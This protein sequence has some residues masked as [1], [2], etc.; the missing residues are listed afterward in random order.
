MKKLEWNLNELFESDDQFYQSIKEVK[1]SVQKFM[2]YKQEILDDAETLKKALIEY[3]KIK[4]KLNNILIYGS[5][6]YYKNINS[7]RA[8]NL[9]KDAECFNNEITTTLKFIDN[10]ILELGLEKIT[11]FIEENPKLKIYELS[12]HNLFRMKTHIQSD[13]INQKIKEINNHINDNINLYNQLIKDIKYGAIEINGKTIEICSSNFAKYISS[14]NREI[15]QKT[16]L[17]VNK[18]FQKESNQFSDILNH[19][20]HYRIEMAKIENY[21]TVLE[22]VLFTE[23]ID[24]K[25]LDSLIE[26]VN[27][28]LN[29]IQEYLKIKSDMLGIETP[30]LYDFGVPLDSDLK[31][32]YSLEDAVSIIKNALSPLGSEYMKAVEYLLNGHIDAIP[33]ENKHQSITFSWHTYSFMNFRGSYV[34]LKNMIHELGHIVN[35]YL[36]KNNLP[37]LYED[38]TIFVGETASIVNEIL[39]NRYLREHAEREEEKLF[40]L[41][42]EIENYFTSVFKQTMYTEYENELYLLNSSEC[43]TSDLLSKKYDELLKKY[44]GENIEYDD[45]ASVE[46]TR[47]GHLY[48]WSYYPYKYATG[49]LIASNVVNSLIDEKT[50]T[51]D[52]YID[53]LSSGSSLYSLDLLKKL[54]IDLTNLNVINDGFKVLKK[55]I[56]ELKKIQS[57]IA[58]NK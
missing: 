29:L 7:E 18:N 10:K 20:I 23:N 50:L 30:H 48:R 19:I 4:E 42:K 54:N 36:S 22:K 15:R 46:W 6:S 43:L 35:Y 58:K 31:I 47:L 41:S 56:N 49:L 45:E 55:D 11:K 2:H 3:W 28:N 33:D 37:F 14:R 40:Y 51:K 13:E 5:L 57:N 32:K 24:S 21:D 27:N 16:Y 17:E 52:Q 53:F 38:S 25:I 8:I 34:D 9:K 39:L 44:Y 1:D 26:S 12:L